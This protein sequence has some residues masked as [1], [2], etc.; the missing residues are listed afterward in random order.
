MINTATVPTTEGVPY[1]HPKQMQKAYSLLITG[2]AA[3]PRNGPLEQTYGNLRSQIEV[4]LD[5]FFKLE[6]GSDQSLRTIGPFVAR[7]LLEVS[8][9]ALLGRLD[10][11]RLLTLRQIQLQPNYEIGD[12][13]MCAIQW[14]GDILPKEK[15]STPWSVDREFP[16]IPRALLSEP[17]EQLFWSAALLGLND[18]VKSDRGGEW[19]A[20]LKKQEPSQFVPR[21]KGDLAK[22]YSSLSKGV[23][24]ELLIPPHT[25]YTRENVRDLFEDTVRW[26]SLMAVLLSFV[27][28]CYNPI[29]TAR[30]IELI[31]EIQSHLNHA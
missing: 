10:P 3:A 2:Q 5:E 30:A 23:H 28:H 4:L 8:L 17:Y 31:E 21:A 12:R 29:S 14:S 15:C 26:S 18:T 9:S 6:A 20:A 27:E 24:H 22:L 1:P 13:I 11:F 25:I 7:S 16:K 19:L